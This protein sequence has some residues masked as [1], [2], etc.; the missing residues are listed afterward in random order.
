MWGC[1]RI[2]LANNKVEIVIDESLNFAKKYSTLESPALL[3]AIIDKIAK[4]DNK[5]YFDQLILNRKY[6]KQA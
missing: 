2:I 1:E 5:I 3:N 6:N 4:S